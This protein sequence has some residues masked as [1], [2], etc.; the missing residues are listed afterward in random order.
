[1]PRLN[2]FVVRL[3][4]LKYLTYREQAGGYYRRSRRWS[5]SSTNVR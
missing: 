5:M 4:M 2:A 1:V 3:G